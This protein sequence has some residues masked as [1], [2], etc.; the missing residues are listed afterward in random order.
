MRSSSSNSINPDE[1]VLV[2]VGEP[3]N[4]NLEDNDDTNV[5]NNN[6]S[7]YEHLFNSYPE[8]TSFDDEQFVWIFMIR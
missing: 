7:D 4:I 3:S 1:L 8:S 6:V 5:D 2:F